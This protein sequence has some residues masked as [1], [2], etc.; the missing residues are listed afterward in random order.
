MQRFAKTMKRDV[1]TIN[2]QNLIRVLNEGS[3][4][5]T[6]SGEKAAAFFFDQ[7]VEWIRSGK[8]L[9]SEQKTVSKMLGL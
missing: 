7:I 5:L 1:T 8:P 3:T 2:P 9:S 4:Q 6:D